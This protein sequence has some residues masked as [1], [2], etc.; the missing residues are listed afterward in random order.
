MVINA[1]CG[2]NIYSVSQHAVEEISDDAGWRGGTGTPVW[3]PAGY[4]CACFCPNDG[5]QSPRVSIGL[6]SHQHWSVQRSEQVL[7]HHIQHTLI[8]AFKLN[9]LQHWTGMLQYSCR[10][11]TVAKCHGNNLAEQSAGSLSQAP[12]W[13]SSLNCTHEREPLKRLRLLSPLERPAL[14]LVVYWREFAFWGFWLCSVM[15]NRPSWFQ[16]AWSSHLHQW[17]M[18]TDFPLNFPGFGV[19]MRV[20]LEWCKDGGDGGLT[21]RALRK[22]GGLTEDKPLIQS[23]LIDNQAIRKRCLLKRLDC[24]SLWYLR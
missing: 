21:E 14:Y 3:P 8:H 5:K 24:T 2:R 11:E 22:Q 19:R 23:G 16:T 17:L 6:A 20:W 1:L 7:T 9:F 10:S 12:S 13:L 18:A 4:Q 15:F